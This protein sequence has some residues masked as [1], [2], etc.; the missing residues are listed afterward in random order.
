MIVQYLP[1]MCQIPPN[2]ANQ[3]V[4]LAIVCGMEISMDLRTLCSR[5]H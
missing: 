5:S 1:A 4:K 2:A 3:R